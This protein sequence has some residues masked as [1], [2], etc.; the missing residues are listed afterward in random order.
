VLRGSF[1]LVLTEEQMEFFE[2]IAKEAFLQVMSYGLFNV[3]PTSDSVNTIHLKTKP[4][5][6]QNKRPG[7]YIIQLRDSGFSVIGQTKDFKKRFNQYTSRFNGDYSDAIN[8]KFY[9][10][11]RKAISENLAYSRIV[12]RFVVYTWVHQNGVALDINSS[13][14]LK[15]QMNYLEYR[16]ILAFFECGLCYNI[17][18]VLP[19]FGDFSLVKIEIDRLNQSSIVMGKVANSQ[20]PKTF[21]PQQMVGPN[22]AKPSSIVSELYFLSGPDYEKFLDAIGPERQNFFARPRL[23]QEL[24]NTIT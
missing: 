19:Q 13:L 1:T 5:G 22:Q 17:E 8:K 11:V 12:Q 15:N 21:D 23:R 6:V 7:V 24:Q 3:T 18:D 20:P 4:G 9:V 16:L 14:I 10:A 2:K